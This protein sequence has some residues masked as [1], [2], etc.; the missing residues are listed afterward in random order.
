MP[1]TITSWKGVLDESQYRPKNPDSP[2]I[3]ICDL[4]NQETGKTWREENA[5]MTHGIPIGVLVEIDHSGI[6][7]FV[8]SHERD[9]DMTPLY[10]LAAD[11]DDTI[12]QRPGF[13]NW[14]WHNG[15]SEDCLTI[16][17]PPSSDTPSAD[18]A[19]HN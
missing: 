2:L 3:T 18:E 10:S 15:Y 8:V 17:K 6:R 4:V 5:E 7:L 16:I 11:P 1:Q 12:R 9:C 13:S 14:K 19:V